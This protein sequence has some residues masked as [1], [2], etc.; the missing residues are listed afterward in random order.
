MGGETYAVISIAGKEPACLK[1]G[2]VFHGMKVTSLSNDFVTL[3]GEASHGSFEV[4]LQADPTF[5][6]QKSKSE[7]RVWIN[8]QANPMLQQAARLPMPVLS[9][10]R[11]L[12]AE[13]R[14]RLIAWYQAFG[15]EFFPDKSSGRLS[16]AS[17]QNIYGQERS[18]VRAAK[19][20]DFEA[21]LSKEKLAEF[22]SA[23]ATRA[24][25]FRE[26]QAGRET[27]PD[28]SKHEENMRRFQASLTPQQ[29]AAFNAH[30]DITQHDWR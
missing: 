13:E 23:Y 6:A 17:Y 24:V 4:P 11:D 30:A 12:P 10:W 27:L 25:N 26:V 2:D 9:R 18:A 14:A 19:L 29:L 1:I 20:R 7:S 28:L 22:K 3:D 16:G 5:L 8:S 21:M 15:W